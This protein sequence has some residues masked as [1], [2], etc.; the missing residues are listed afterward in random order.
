MYKKL[1]LIYQ[2][3]QEYPLAKKAFKIMLQIAW[4]END[5]DAEMKAYELIAMQYF[6]MQELKKASFYKHKAFYGDLERPEGV[7]MRQANNKR[8]QYQRRIQN[9]KRKVK[10]E[11]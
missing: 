10:A 9:G 8:L 5:T 4:C 7:C 11:R 3:E 1:G 2:S 6:Y